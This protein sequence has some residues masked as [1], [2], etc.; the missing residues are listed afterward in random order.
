MRFPIFSNHELTFL[1][2]GELAWVSVIHLFEGFDEVIELRGEE[3]VS[4]GFVLLPEEEQQH[5][6]FQLLPI[7]FPHFAHNVE[8]GLVLGCNRLILLHQHFHHVLKLLVLISEEANF[9]FQAF[10]SV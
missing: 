9:S 4:L 10:F 1:F 8:E 6:G 5:Q 7:L 3:E 2:L